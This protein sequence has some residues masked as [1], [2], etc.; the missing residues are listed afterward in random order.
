MISEWV[1]ADAL[2]LVGPSVLLDVAVSTGDVHMLKRMIP[3]VG[4]G[5]SVSKDAVYLAAEFGQNEV[6]Q[7]LL[8]SGAPRTHAAVWAA[9]RR[10]NLAAIQ[11]LVK[12]GLAFTELAEN[13][14]LRHGHT[15]IPVCMKHAL[16]P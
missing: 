8:E 7:C 14:C 16:L 5:T 3:A 10:G 4:G 11:M 6:L 1:L 12:H 2:S 9:C 13:I 15:F